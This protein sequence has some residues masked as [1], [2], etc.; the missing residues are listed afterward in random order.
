MN[1]FISFIAWI[2]SK[3][4]LDKTTSERWGDDIVLSQNNAMRVLKSRHWWGC[5]RRREHWFGPIPYTQ[6]LEEASKPDAIFK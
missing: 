4:F 5:E 1:F 2:R 6:E 3:I